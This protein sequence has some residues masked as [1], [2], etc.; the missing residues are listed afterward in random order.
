MNFIAFDAAYSIY[1][2]AT[3]E[4]RHALILSP[5]INL[6]KIA[7]ALGKYARRGWSFTTDIWSHDKNMR[8]K[9]FF[10]DVGRW[11]RDR[12]SWVVPLDVSGIERPPLSTSSV[13]FSWDPVVYN[14]WRLTHL[15]PQRISV[16]F[17]KLDST[18]F[19]YAYLVADAKLLDM[20]QEFCSTQGWL[21]RIKVS[22]FCDEDKIKYWTW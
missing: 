2:K 8:E 21:E 19:R 10:L 11:V 18:I 7:I 14:S 1:P 3:F 6:R 12:H 9:T 20:L 15:Q 5:K 13:G 22:T 16:A 17:L 4:D